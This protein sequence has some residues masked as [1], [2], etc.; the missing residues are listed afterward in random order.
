ME[1]SWWDSLDGWITKKYNQHINYISHIIFIPRG[2]YIAR[3]ISHLM[4]FD[5]DRLFM[6]LHILLYYQLHL[7][8]SGL[9]RIRIFQ[10]LYVRRM[11]SKYH[12]PEHARQTS[13]QC[14]CSL[15]ADNRTWAYSTSSIQ[16][17]IASQHRSQEI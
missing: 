9:G 2:W 13:H 11:R 7:S 17:W 5:G 14:Q 15:Y 12:K 1:L 3:Y 10:N 4:A 6:K 8:L 16:P